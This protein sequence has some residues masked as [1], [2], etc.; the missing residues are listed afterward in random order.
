MC[1][2]PVDNYFT[3]FLPLWPNVLD[4]KLGFLYKKC[5]LWVHLGAKL[6]AR[7]KSALWLRHF[8]CPTWIAAFDNLHFVPPYL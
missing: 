5:V 2:Y 3:F 1:Y 4:I 6:W 8:L 7:L